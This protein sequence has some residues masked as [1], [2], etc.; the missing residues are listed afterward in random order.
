MKSAT[1]VP[2]LMPRQLSKLIVHCRPVLE[3]LLWSLRNGSRGRGVR[4]DS[5]PSPLGPGGIPQGAQPGRLRR[6]HQA[7]LHR[8]PLSQPSRQQAQPQGAQREQALLHIWISGVLSV[9]LLS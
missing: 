4:E 8:P 2:F 6:H 3:A 7:E 5:L 1:D 9:L